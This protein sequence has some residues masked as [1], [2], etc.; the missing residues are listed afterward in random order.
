MQTSE[1]AS[2]FSAMS[3]E[4]RLELLR[5]LISKGPTG[6][7][8]GDIALRLGLSPSNASF[9]LAALERAGLTQSTRQ[10]RQIIHSVR[11]VTLRTV[12]AFLT[13]ACCDGRPD[14]CGD[15]ARLLP[16]LPSEDPAMTPAFNVLFL[17]THNAARSIMA[18]TILESIANGRFHAYS[19]GSEPGS[20]PNPE[21]LAKLATLGHD[22]AALRSKSWQEFAGPNAPRMDF[23][24][25]LCDALDGQVCP[26]FG[27]VPVT[28]AW[29]LPD[30][31]KFMGSAVER[32]ALINELYA[33]LR[34]RLEIF[35]SLPFASL[36]R[37]AIRARLDEI[38]GGIPTPAG[39]R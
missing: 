36:D 21:V 19:A 34:R 18:E 39:G 1:I 32:A 25:T 13:E 6:L 3:Q 37:L 29:P 11:F 28:A 7:A 16:P 38:G 12:F 27:P 17:C 8:A 4:V 22:T 33:S 14:L 10:G 31:A 35:T 20:G 2:V 24:I 15:I 9:H 5:L 26:D 23:I 30:P